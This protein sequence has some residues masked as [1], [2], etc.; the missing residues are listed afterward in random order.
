MFDRLETGQG[1]TLEGVRIRTSKGR[2]SPWYGRQ[3][4]AAVKAFVAE[5]ESPIVGFDRGMSGDCPP[6]VGVRL[7]DDPQ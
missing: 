5:E 1:A 7:L 4:G 6:I 3:Y 2:E